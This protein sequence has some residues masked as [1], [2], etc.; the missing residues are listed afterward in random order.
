MGHSHNHDHNAGISPQDARYREVRVVTLVGAVANLILAVFK[1]LFGVIGSSQSLVADGIHSLSDLLSDAMVLFAA[2]H[3]A[4]EA[5]DEHPY[6]H[7]RIETVF[8]VAL[9][10]LLLLVAF[11]LSWD[12]V[13]RLFHPDL[14]TRP[15]TITLWVALISVLSKEVL[16]HYTVRVARRIRS[17]LLEANAWHHRSD[18]VS[19]LVVIVGIGGTLA[20]LPYLDAIAAVG[21]ALMIAKI[22]WE[23]AW[24]SVHELI[25]TGLAQ[26]RVDEIR[27]AIQAFDGVEDQHLLRTRRMGGEA[28]ADVH[29]MVDPMLSVSEG[30]FISE[31][32]RRRL[33]EQ[34]DELQDVL[35]HIDPEDD[36]LH[37]VN[38]KLPSRRQ[39]LAQLE[40]AWS[41][42]PA[43]KQRNKLT[44]HY[45]QGRIR[46]ELMLPL[47]EYSDLEQKNN[48]QIELDRL[49]EGFDI[50]ESIRVCY[51]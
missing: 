10:I 40:P 41:H 21:V 3:G 9:G 49:A 8:T 27:A 38:T 26:S 39:L 25:D 28:L 15:E 42:L 24:E 33:I 29:I 32:L 17:R 36:Q 19:S 4:K 7:G 23:L 1:V 45:L 48:L 5:D 34:F 14:L 44:L 37:P 20:G 2:K 6:G 51:G 46:V 18:A 43:L 13:R 11:G 31:T 12:A 16:Y 30:H 47:S 35:V 22:G 50:I